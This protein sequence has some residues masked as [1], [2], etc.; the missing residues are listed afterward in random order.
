MIHRDVAPE[1]VLLKEGSADVL[2][3]AQTWRE[4]VVQAVL[5]IP[6]RPLRSKTGKHLGSASL[7]GPIWAAFQLSVALQSEVDPETLQEA[8]VIWREGLQA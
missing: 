4:Q 8:Q 6:W 1:G 3:L 5:R 7:H 2:I